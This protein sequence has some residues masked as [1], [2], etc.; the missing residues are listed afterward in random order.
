MNAS[1]RTA[2]L[3]LIVVIVGALAWT[4]VPSQAQ[5]N[6]TPITL[7]LR[8]GTTLNGRLAGVTKAGLDVNVDGLAMQVNWNYL[9]PDFAW[10]HYRG[11]FLKG[12]PGASEL[13]EAA[14]WCDRYALPEKARSI[15]LDVVNRVDPDNSIAHLALGHIKYQ[16]HWMTPDDR[17]ALIAAAARDGSGTGATVERPNNSAGNTGNASNSGGS[18]NTG[19]ASNSGNAGNAGNAG[20]TGNTSNGSGS[21]STARGNFTI[22]LDLTA[23][24]VDADQYT[25][26]V[27]PSRDINADVASELS[28][29]GVRTV[30]TGGDYTATG[31]ATL[32]LRDH[33]EFFGATILLRY[34]GAIVITLK[35]NG[36]GNE[37]ETTVESIKRGEVARDVM[38]ST[39]ADLARRA[40]PAIINLANRVR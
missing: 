40:A 33:S 8:D 16:G 31:E 18:G 23:V 1:R 38:D 35:A 30:A 17:D 19:N 4:A 24:Q 21:G 20:N 6:G 29:R 2:C 28:S 32:A 15:Y 37:N 13:I 34:E 22:V 7:V 25:R 36:S 27:V 26:D 39:I 9:D 5:D 11:Q 10:E 3:L 12:T 14:Q